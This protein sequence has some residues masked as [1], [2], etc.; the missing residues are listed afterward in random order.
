L[1]LSSQEHQLLSG[2]FDVLLGKFELMG[3][4]PAARGIPRIVVKFD[5]D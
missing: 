2:C 3:I 5:V 1:A 4:P